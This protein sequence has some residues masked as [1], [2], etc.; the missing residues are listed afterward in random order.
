MPSCL[1]APS[2]PVRTSRIIHFAHIATEVQI[3]WP[4]TT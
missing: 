4:S 2:L 3:F 1:E